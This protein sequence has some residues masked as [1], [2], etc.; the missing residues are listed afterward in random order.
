[1]VKIGR[2]SRRKQFIPALEEFFNSGGVEGTSRV[3]P[4]TNLDDIKEGLN[5][6]WLLPQREDYQEFQLNERMHILGRTTIYVS[7]KNPN[8][9]TSLGTYDNSRTPRIY[10]NSTTQLIPDLIVLDML[11]QRKIYVVD[12]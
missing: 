9:L 1:M 12:V 5:V 6:L 11:E 8:R 10:L 7:Y 3:R 2:K 4:V